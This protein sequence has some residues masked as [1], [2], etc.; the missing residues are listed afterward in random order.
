MDTQAILKEE[1]VPL[2][3]LLSFELK[4][5]LDKIYR[6]LSIRQTLNNPWKVV[7]TNNIHYS[8]YYKFSHAI[9]DFSIKFGLST[10]I[11]VRFTEI[12]S[13]IYHL[14]KGLD[15]SKDSARPYLNKKV[16]DCTIKLKATENEPIVM[17]Y[18]YSKSKV[19]ISGA[20][21]VKNSY[22]NMVST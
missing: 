21:E 12:A 15:D 11:K 1:K 9:R 14:S 22:G 8:I 18:A 5:I 4:S 17:E 13:A 16:K 10:S 6:Q 19:T 2:H 3:G 7:V 20:Y